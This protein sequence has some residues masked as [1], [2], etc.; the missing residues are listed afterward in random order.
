[1]NKRV[2][3]A[4]Q[5]LFLLIL[6]LF[7]T[8]RKAFAED[9]KKIALFPFDTYSEADTTELRKA[10]HK[11][12]TME[13]QKTKF[14]RLI[15]PGIISS[16]I[17]GKRINE[18]LAIAVGKDTGAKFVVTGSLSQFGDMISLDARIIDVSQ[19]K[20]LPPIFIQGK[21]P[22]NINEIVT[23]LKTETLI[24]IAT[25]QRI[26]RIEFKG[27]RKIETSAISQVLQGTPGSFF[28]EED[29]SS[30]IKAIYKMGYFQDV[31][32]DVN[33]TPEGKVIT[34]IL[35]EKALVTEVKIKGNKAVGRE[36]IET[37][38]S[39]K[40]RQSLNPDVIK[41]DTEKIK[42]LYD[43]KGYYNAE[44]LDA[45]EKVDDTT[46]RVVFNI[47]ENKKLYIKR[48]T[49]EGNQAYTNK[50]LRKMMSTSE[51]SIFRFL[52]DAGLLKKD[53]LKQ[54]VNKLQVFYLNSGFINAQ[55]GEPEIT[56]DK[57]WIYVK[58]SVTEGK[59]F[60]I[61]KV[62]IAGDEP[63]IAR[64]ELLK[65]I[66][67]NKKEYFDRASIMRDIE[68]LTQICNDEGYA[69]AEITPQTA[70]H[71]K[72]Q[73]VDVTYN[74]AKGSQVYFNRITIT[75]N[76]KTRDKV[77]R[78]QLDVVE[79]ALY[80]S[81]N[82]KK[83]Y[84][85]LN[86]LRYFEEV[87][88][89]TEKG[90]DEALTDV[91]IHVKEKPTGFFSLGAGYSAVDQAIITGQISQQNLFGR[92]QSL[93]LKAYL[94]STVTSYDVSFV[95]PWLFDIPLW[96]KFDLW[97]LTRAYDAYDLDS[98]GFGITFG[99]PVWEYVTGYVGYRLTSD[100]VSNLDP[101]MSLY[102]MAQEGRRTTSSITISLVRDTTDDYIFPSKGS[103]NS[104]SLEQAGTILQG[105]TSF[106]KYQVS[107]TWFFPLFREVVFGIRGR[108][109]Y[110][111]AHE[112][113]DLPIYERFYLGG[114]N[115]LR[116]LKEVGPVDPWTGDLI[117]GT[118]MLN[119]NA[120]FLFPLI[121]SAGMKGV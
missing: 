62:D 120:E 5:V 30:D 13:L 7:P 61:G 25:E 48:I 95:E 108:G 100:A 99:Y 15:E 33:D 88:F 42:A 69:Y 1:M 38:L 84:T 45:I 46:V 96:T 8:S 109:G 71:E 51:T 81:S 63:K 114:I 83:S 102:L 121:K 28:S 2:F 87:N 4:V 20:V 103:K 80:S 93:S 52:T 39:T 118:T 78:R 17:E 86:R 31:A 66:K 91:N 89:Q 14:L 90:P 37:I 58:I 9:V 105:D 104:I 94:G 11:G 111:Q 18:K 32:A 21:V 47:I 59:R 97:N 77:I 40:A 110:L 19:E 106:T 22:A 119:A 44:V 101:L 36:E 24:R 64:A 16:A 53:Q 116:G 6:F 74:I 72:E 3:V 70:P 29:L 75:G 12:I 92:G 23:Q 65:N 73:L 50:E 60:R 55:V 112:G 10:I 43:N 41:E 34:F 67:I 115:S 49:F 117:G 35:K 54:D 85:A 107:S 113:K 82:L 56:Y 26:I 27:N 68:Y 79:G 76:T 57:K 98:S